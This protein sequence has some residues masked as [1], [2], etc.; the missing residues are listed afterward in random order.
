M[1][2]TL[3]GLFIFLVLLAP[4]LVF[5][6]ALEHRL[7]GRQFSVFR[8][9]ASVAAVGAGCDALVLI[10]FAIFRTIFPRATPDIGSIFR[11]PATYWHSH[12]QAILLWGFG[13]FLGACAIGAL[14]GTFWNSDFFSE[15]SGWWEVFVDAYREVGEAKSVV[16]FCELSDQ[17]LVAGCLRSFN[18]DPRDIGDRDIV[19]Q[20]PIYRRLPGGDTMASGM[21]SAHLLPEFGVISVSGR[22]IISV[23]AKFFPY[24]VSDTIN[25]PPDATIPV[26]SAPGSDTR[27]LPIIASPGRAWWKIWR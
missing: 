18:T 1:P 11:D 4:G 14:L 13:L 5:I 3:V 12:Y 16:V 25:F 17:T 24:D 9:T 23:M 22:H 6:F 7:P 15:K 19:L 2:T 20:S 21:S 26:P 8:E 10:F 27:E